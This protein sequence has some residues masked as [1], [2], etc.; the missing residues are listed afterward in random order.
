VER[1]IVTTVVVSMRRI[2]VSL[3]ASVAVIMVGIASSSD[4][5]AS[6]WAPA[7]SATIHP[8][9]QLFIR[10]AQCTANF[11]FTDNSHIYVGE[12]AHCARMDARFSTDGCTSPSLPL[13]TLVEIPGAAREGRLVYSSW[14][15]MKALQES[16]PDTCRYNDFALVEVDPADANSINPSMPIW[17]GPEGLTPAGMAEGEP[18]YGYG[19]SKL[20]L[21]VS[22]LSPRQGVTL[23]LRGGGWSHVV[24]GVP[25]AIPG[26]SGM[27]YL[28]S[29]GRALGIL[30][31]L[32]LVPTPGTNGVGDLSLELDYLRAHSPLTGVQLAVGTEPFTAAPLRTIRSMGAVLTRG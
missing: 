28:D 22:A 27:A 30:S 15:A 32:D 16:D 11:I 17:G 2:A 31:T 26:D 21:G 12:A 4:S 20:G 29:H 24:L 1:Y 8:G 23:G 5:D 19:H 14:V 9:V 25:P 13:G 10:D 18:V 3:V 6:Q 7:A